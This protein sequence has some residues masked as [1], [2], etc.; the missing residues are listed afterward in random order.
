MGPREYI[1]MPVTAILRMT[2]D[3]FTNFGRV[4]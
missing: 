2:I 1:K 4:F 3:D